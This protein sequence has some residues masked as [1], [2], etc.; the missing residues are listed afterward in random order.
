MKLHPVTVLAALLA[1]LSTLPPAT[2]AQ[3][4]EPTEEQILQACARNTAASL[5]NPYKDLSPTHWAYRAVLSLHYC[6]AYRG[7]VPPER[8][9]KAINL[10]QEQ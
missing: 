8:L 3:S 4:S 2:F 6:G 5:P 1:L 10:P 9:R 7:A